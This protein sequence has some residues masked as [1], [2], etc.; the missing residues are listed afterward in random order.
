M[1]PI[2]LFQQ[3]DN[4]FYGGVATPLRR[5][6]N[7][8]DVEHIKVDKK[9]VIPE[10]NLKNPDLNKLK[11]I[12]PKVE[13]VKHSGKDEE[14]NIKE[15]PKEQTIG[16][17]ITNFINNPLEVDNNQNMEIEAKRERQGFKIVKGEEALGELKRD[18]EEV[19]TEIK[20]EV[21]EPVY[22]GILEGA[23]DIKKSIDSTIQKAQNLGNSLLMFGGALLILFV[24]KK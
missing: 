24:L 19:G 7:I 21:I 14:P 22:S 8:K 13:P 5:E 17:R 10:Y 6:N 16:E 4:D 11:N 23:E 12:N 1:P 15:E 9:K 20:R 3:N 2:L 18:V